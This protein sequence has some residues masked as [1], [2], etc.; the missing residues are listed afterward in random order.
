MDEQ[1]RRATVELGR[2]ELLEKLIDIGTALSAERNRDRLFERILIEAMRFCGAD[3]GTLYLR[4]KADEL[5]FAI[6][7][8]TSLGTAIGG[9]TGIKAPFAAIPLKDA[10]GREN[11]ATVVSHVAL[12]GRTMNIP[13]IARATTFDFSGTRAFDEANGYRSTSFL[14]LPL[15]DSRADVIGVLQLINAQDAR[16]DVVAFPASIEPL[17]EALASQAAVALEN[18]LLLEAQRRLLDSFIR[19]IAAA[20]DAKSPF[21]GE[22]CQRVPAIM[23]MFADAA[24]AANDGPFADF[25]LDEDERYELHIAAWLHDCGKVAVPEYVVDKATKLH[26]LYDRIET[27]RLRFEI[28]KR[29]AEIAFLKRVT[30]GEDE[31]TQRAAFEREI[32]S[33]ED[34]FRVVLQSNLGVEDMPDEDVA[35][36]HAIAE[37]RVWTDANGERRSVL[38]ENEVRNLTIRRGNLLPEERDMINNHIVV[39]IDMLQHLPFPAEL[40]RVPEY[41]GGH[42]ERMDGKG[43]P[44][45][46]TRDDMSVPARMMAIADIFEALT[47]PDRPYKQAKKLSETMEIMVGM[48]NNNHIDP[49]LF[50]LFVDS[51][52]HRRFAESFLEPWQADLPAVDAVLARFTSP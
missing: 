2:A 31:A 38:T 34:D 35:R 21:T 33:I 23:N 5:D 4:N 32:D 41:A 6:V 43:Y 39:T 36:I 13:D 46:L 18:R 49:D 3:G 15:K 12:T 51:G 16:G 27:V 9:S 52:V 14:T 26:T 11:H 10:A 40:A 25:A 7:R 8:T 24:C 28:L 1:V 29:D 22:H 48:V 45:G 47:S 42:H 20:I 44:R 50:R 37:N 19:L 30:P 17:A